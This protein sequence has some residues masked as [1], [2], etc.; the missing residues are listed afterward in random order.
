MERE[1]E[2]LRRRAIEFLKTAEFLFSQKSFDLV[3]FHLGQFCQLY[4]KYALL[5]KVGDFP[6]THSYGSWLPC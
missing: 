3:A 6:K 2:I 1:A 5:R 4:L